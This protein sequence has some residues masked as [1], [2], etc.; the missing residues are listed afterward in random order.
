MLSDNH[1][2]MTTPK[3]SRWKRVSSTDFSTVE[4]VLKAAASLMV[5]ADQTQHQAFLRLVPYLYVYRNKGCSFAQ[6]ATLLGQCG[7][8]LQPSTV[9]EYYNAAL[10]DRMDVCQERMNEQILILA[11]VRKQTQ[12]AEISS[13]SERAIAVVERH[14]T[15][16]AG[17]LDELFGGSSIAPVP[18]ASAPASLEAE[19]PFLV[20]NKNSGLRPAPSTQLPG[21]PDNESGCFGLLN[22]KV[23]TKKRAPNVPAFFSQDESAPAIPNIR[24]LSTDTE[25]QS[26]KLCP[27]PSFSSPTPASHDMSLKATG[28]RCLALK[29][30]P[31]PLKKREGISPDVYQ[32]GDLEHPRITG[33]QLSLDDRLYSSALEYTNENG[34]IKLETLDEKRFRI[35]W[36]PIIPMTPTMTSGCFTQMDISSYKKQKQ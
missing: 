11:E 36:K 9:R 21:L 6:L 27:A 12:G 15:A 22:L 3:P 14:R 26:S 34:E 32:A 25:N 20:E 19:K 24:S 31:Q 23:M 1:S 17:K 33:L 7:I 13:I 29:V 2:N 28:L 30:G 4:E 16:A 10:A 35:L 5:P 8:N 18:R